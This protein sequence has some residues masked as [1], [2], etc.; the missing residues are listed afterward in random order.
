[1]KSVQWWPSSFKVCLHWEGGWVSTFVWTC[2]FWAPRPPYFLP[3]AESVSRTERGIFPYVSRFAYIPRKRQQDFPHLS[4]KKGDRSCCQQC[5]R[6]VFVVVFGNFRARCFCL[7][8]LRFSRRRFAYA[9]F[10][11]ICISGF[12]Y[13]TFTI[14]LSQVPV[15]RVT[16]GRWFFKVGVARWF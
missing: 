4:R 13:V 5:P 16:C 8:D 12:L 6:F 10:I 2:A 9:T 1:M 3:T 7:G 11:Y 14:V 15:C